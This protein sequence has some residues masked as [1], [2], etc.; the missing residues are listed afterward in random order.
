MKEPTMPVQ[1]FMEGEEVFHGELMENGSGLCLSSQTNQLNLLHY[2]ADT[3]AVEAKI[4]MQICFDNQ[5]VEGGEFYQSGEYY[6][7]SAPDTSMQ[8]MNPD[9]LAKLY[10]EEHGQKAKLEISRGH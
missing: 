1:I 7:L 9:S 6:C 5:T 8:L 2:A 4:P 10:I 3:E